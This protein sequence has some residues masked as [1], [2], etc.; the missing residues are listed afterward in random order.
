MSS[1]KKTSGVSTDCPVQTLIIMYW[2]DSEILVWSLILLSNVY[3]IFFSQVSRYY[4]GEEK[5]DAD[6][7][8]STMI[9]PGL[10]PAEISDLIIF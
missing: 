5:T 6:R 4:P 7:I 3:I 2:Y 1:N 8:F 10:G 9:T